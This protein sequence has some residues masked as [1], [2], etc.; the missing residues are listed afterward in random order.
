MK[1]W[2]A[3]LSVLLVTLT[4]CSSESDKEYLL[5]LVKDAEAKMVTC[6]DEKSADA[7]GECM[8]SA[9]QTLQSEWTDNTGRLSGLD[10]KEAEEVA[11]AYMQLSATIQ[12]E[13]F[14]IMMQHMPKPE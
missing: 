5:A 2:I 9:M 3:T 11:A 14:K 4:A 10:E 12:Q 6:K 8:S 7:I 13:M 1:I